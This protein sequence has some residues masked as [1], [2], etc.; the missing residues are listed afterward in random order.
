MKIADVMHTP[1]GQMVNL[2]G[3][4]SSLAGLELKKSRVT[5]QMIPFLS[6]GLVDQSSVVIEFNLWG[7]TCKR[8]NLAEEDVIQV[9]NAQVTEYQ[10]VK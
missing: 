6:V 4:V 10:G 5:G 3:L 7:D 2:F 8:Y 1:A 9:L